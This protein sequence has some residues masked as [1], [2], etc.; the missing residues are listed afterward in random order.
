MKLTDDE[1]C[2]AQARRLLA[3]WHALEDELTHANDEPVG[4]LRCACRA[5]SA[6]ISWSR[7]W[8]ST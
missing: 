2:Y 3:T 1:R 7:R 6:R 4:T 8:W 5:P